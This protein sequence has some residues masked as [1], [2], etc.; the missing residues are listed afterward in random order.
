MRDSVIIGG[1]LAGSSLAT[2]LARS[3]RETLLI[4]KQA[5]PHNKV[6]GEFLS[7][8]AIGYLRDIACDVASL[9]A[10]PI[11][12]IRLVGQKLLGEKRLP[13]PAVSLDRY[14]LDEALMAG[15]LAAGAEIQRGKRAQSLRQS[16]CHWCVQTSNQT[17][18]ARDVFLACGKHDIGGWQRPSG[19]QSDL[20]G[21]KMHWHV[22][23]NTAADLN[24][25]IEIILFRG[26]YAGLQ[27][28]GPTT[29]NLAL[30][31]DRSRYKAMGG[32]W[33]ALLAHMIKS[34]R[35]LELRLSDA[36]STWPAPLAISPIPYGYLHSGNGGPW[37]LGD[38]AAVI[39]SFSGSG[40]SIALHSAALAAEVY[41]W[42]GSAAD[43]HRK[44]RRNLRGKI[45]LAV[46]LSRALVS[47]YCK[48][49]IASA[50]SN[51]P[52]LLSMAA[53]RTRIPEP[54]SA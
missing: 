45:G 17:L 38:Q 20:I 47:D 35:H 49:V 26:G 3:G 46:W 42:G 30:L 53:A 54:V 1:G 2:R 44:L 21:F 14:I 27:L 41:L 34:S 19:R 36:T 22:S 10:L 8:E 12:H 52:V 40:M 28:I 32:H 31:I 7:G 11:T 18:H 37:R 6:C 13:F 15:A 43:Y 23:A 29:A 51:L 9:G 16:D 48:P 25:S 33:S 39:S 4:E 24:E 50:V 5:A